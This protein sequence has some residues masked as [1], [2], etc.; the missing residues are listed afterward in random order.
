MR[1]IV[2]LSVLFVFTCSALSAQNG[3]AL[4]AHKDK[5]IF[6]NAIPTSEYDVVG[7]A[8]YSN[9]KKNEQQTMGDVSGLAKVVL[10]LDDANEK[11]EKGKQVPYDAAIVYGP[12]KIEL[13]KFKTLDENKNR[14]CNVG[15]KDYS[16]KY[17]SKI[18]YF[19]S[20][21]LKE[22]DIAKDITVKNF[23]NLGQM[24]MGKNNND[25]FLNKLYE[26][27]C[28]EAKAG[29]D[30][31]AVIFKDPDVINKRGFISSKNITL[32]KFK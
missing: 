28:K 13:I 11:V 31:D 8:K 20:L 15:V 4:V 14:E 2:I 22:Y 17:G 1:K 3:Y 29:V 30:F 27:S 26:R 9:S 5:L 23:T 10:A 16:R 24:K 12:I 6:I 19:M 25:N 18:M 21:P 32:I 7:K